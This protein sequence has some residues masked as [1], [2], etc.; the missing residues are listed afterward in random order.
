MEGKKEGNIFVCMRKYIECITT[1]GKKSAWK[2]GNYV[3]YKF[4][5]L[6]FGGKKR[7]NTL[8]PQEKSAGKRGNILICSC[9]E[10]KKGK[11]YF[12]EKIQSYVIREECLMEI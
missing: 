10:E 2:R 7:E 8:L 3:R 12:R 9:E 6:I 5:F 11:I 4:V 1:T